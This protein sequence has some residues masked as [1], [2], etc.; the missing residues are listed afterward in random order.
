M[1]LF[2]SRRA[3]PPQDPGNQIPITPVDL[4]KR[5]DVYCST[6]NN[7][8]RLYEGARFVGIRTFDRISEYSSGLVSGYLEIEAG[9]GSRW[10]IPS[11][12]ILLIC[13]HGARPVFKVRRKGEPW[14]Y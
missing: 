12:G 7:E 5:Y 8:E 11:F 10:L 9:D 14:D 3:Q 2:H 1:G 4:S 13:E 6:G